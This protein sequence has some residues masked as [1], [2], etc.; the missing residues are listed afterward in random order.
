MIN[1]LISLNE[2]RIKD[3]K[4]KLSLNFKPDKSTNSDDLSEDVLSFKRCTEKARINLA[5]AVNPL[6]LS[7]NKVI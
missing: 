3:I 7:T 2:L 4:K 1:L 6:Q 5:P